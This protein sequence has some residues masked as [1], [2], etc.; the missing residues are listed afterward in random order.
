MTLVGYAIRCD[1]VLTPNICFVRPEEKPTAA[2]GR[3]MVMMKD[4]D[5]LWGGHRRE[6]VALYTAEEVEDKIW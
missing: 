2:A 5:V 6:V 3:A 1:G 4:M